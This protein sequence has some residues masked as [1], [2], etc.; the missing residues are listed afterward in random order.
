MKAIR[1]FLAGKEFVDLLDKNR[2]S[3][4]TSDVTVKGDNIY[5]DQWN[6][7]WKWFGES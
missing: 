2:P 7:G 5:D 6:I 3:N 4:N 1:I